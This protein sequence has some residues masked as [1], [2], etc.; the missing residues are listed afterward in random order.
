MKMFLSFFM[1]VFFSAN[2][3]AQKDIV[4]K[5][6]ENRI[7]SL[8]N[9]FLFEEDEDLL[10]LFDGSTNFQFLYW[11]ANYHT[12]TFYAGRQI[13]YNQYNLSSQL[14]YLHSKGFYVGLAGAWYSDLDPA[15]RTTVLSFG[16]GKGLR[17]LKFLRYRASF[18]LY[19]YN[20]NDP[21][22]DPIYTSSLNLG[23][24][25]KSKILSTRFDAAFLL[26]KEIGTQLNWDIYSKITLLKLGKFNKLQF[27]P[28]LSFF[29]GSETV[30]Y[31]LSAYLY[32]QF[33]DIPPTYYYEDVFG[34][35]NTQLTFPLSLSAGNFDFELSIQKNFPR[36][37]DYAV[38]Y[39]ESTFLSFSIGYIFNLR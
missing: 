8:L 9:D 18:D 28:E 26:G 37:M 34:L 31:D 39:E 2:V 38:E 24:S 10:S 20:N 14:F 12:K 3:F 32:D 29:F 22:Y 23:T 4:F 11:R 36:S 35:M 33:P 25:L 27:E 16:Y 17:K 15:Y 6:Q 19:F 1:V 30:E 21:D 5:I 13:G 7:D